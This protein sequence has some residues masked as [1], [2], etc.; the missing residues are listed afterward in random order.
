[1]GAVAKKLLKELGIE[2]VGYVKTIGGIDAK[3][4]PYQ[5]MEQLKQKTEESP[6]RCFDKEVEQQMMDAID[7][8][9]EE[10]DSI[11]GIVEVVV[12]GVPAG[13]GSYTQYDR[14]LDAKIAQ[15]MLSINA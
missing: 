12:E 7:K 14:K 6:V 10:G 3:D 5:S 2:V 13:L 11:G 4:L 1:A 15:A 8:A 9:K